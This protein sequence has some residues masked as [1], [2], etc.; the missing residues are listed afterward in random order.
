M[1]GAHDVQHT[2]N[3]FLWVHLKDSCGANAGADLDAFTALC[4]GVKHKIDA[5][6]ESRLE[7]EIVH[8]AANPAA[9]YSIREF[10]DENPNEVNDSFLLG[11]R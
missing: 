11:R 9:S 2:R 3:D 8:S 7:G 10:P 1:A 6:C 5:I 4:A